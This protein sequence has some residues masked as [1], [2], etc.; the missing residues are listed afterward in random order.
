M[1]T[2]IMI[3]SSS[4]TWHIFACLTLS[5]MKLV[6]K[7]YKK[8][9]RNNLTYKVFTA[10]TAISTILAGVFGLLAFLFD[11]N[12]DPTSLPDYVDSNRP[13]L[14]AKL[15]IAK[16]DASGIAY[17][18]HIKNIG[19]LPAKDLI[20]GFRSE[21]FMRGEFIAENRMLAPN[22]SIEIKNPQI[23]NMT[24]ADLMDINNF[25]L[26]ASFKSDIA[27]K[28]KLYTSLFKFKIAFK[29]VK[30]GIFST[31]DVRRTEGRFTQNE[32]QKY[33]NE[34]FP[35]IQ[36]RR[37]I[38]QS[39]ILKAHTYAMDVIIKETDGPGLK[40]L[41]DAGK[42]NSSNRISIFLDG[43]NNFTFRIIDDKGQSA[44]LVAKKQSSFF[45]RY[46]LLSAEYTQ[47]VDFTILKLYI[48]NS[49]IGEKR[50]R[51]LANIGEPDYFAKNTRIVGFGIEPN[52]QANA[53][54]ANYQIIT[55]ILT[56]SLRNQKLKKFE[57]YRNKKSK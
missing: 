2:I 31:N 42:D 1:G 44:E 40:F 23:I 11:K 49:L 51:Y 54:V 57:E 39:E 52:N 33:L 34:E 32:F 24:T 3:F 22:E 56:D 18:Y 5:L 48:N 9:N 41:M 30:E 4:L 37:K 21:N 17:D 6:E 13:Y 29:D 26:R 25:V 14:E 10:L 28:E 7:F 36:K 38:K 43:N 15:L 20:F 47:G 50:L 46:I 45:N 35:K 53:H 27:K 55:G 12:T 16:K 19:A 8:W